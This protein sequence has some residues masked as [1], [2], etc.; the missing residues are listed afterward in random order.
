MPALRAVHRAPHPF[1]SLVGKENETT[2]S[3]GARSSGVADLTVAV[4]AMKDYCHT[5]HRHLQRSNNIG[6]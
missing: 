1:T 6:R 4:V 5:F 2:T 3:E